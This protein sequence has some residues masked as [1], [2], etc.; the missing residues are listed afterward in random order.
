M[1]EKGLRNLIA[2]VHVDSKSTNVE[3]DLRQWQALIDLQAR[4]SE[5]LRQVGE[6]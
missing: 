4:L 1:D 5:Y 2:A 6:P 3:L